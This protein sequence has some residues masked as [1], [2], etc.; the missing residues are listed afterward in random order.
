MNSSADVNEKMAIAEVDPIARLNG[1]ARSYDHAAGSAAE[2]WET[3]EK[4]KS[5]GLQ[6]VPDGRIL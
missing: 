1:L 4:A 5:N 6:T 3:I 2:S